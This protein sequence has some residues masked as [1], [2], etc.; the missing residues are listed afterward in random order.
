MKPQP[1]LANAGLE[2]T[3]RSQATAPAHR[4]KEAAKTRVMV[5][6][7]RAERNLDR[8]LPV[9]RIEEG[10]SPLVAGRSVVLGSNLRT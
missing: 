4:S 10:T 5:R 1:N 3:N 8:R 2:A 6:N 9:S 7:S